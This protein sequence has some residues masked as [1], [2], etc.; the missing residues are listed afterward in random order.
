LLNRVR[1][2]KNPKQ[3]E[4]VRQQFLNTLT[5]EETIKFYKESMRLLKG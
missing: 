2:L 5:L 1:A 4:C 3:A